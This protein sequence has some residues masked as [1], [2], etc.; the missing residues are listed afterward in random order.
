[1]RIVFALMHYTSEFTLIDK[2][3]GFGWHLGATWAQHVS[4]VFYDATLLNTIA[5]MTHFVGY[6]L[7]THSDRLYYRK[8]HYSFHLV[9]VLFGQLD[10]LF[11]NSEQLIKQII[12]LN[13]TLGF[14]GLLLVSDFCFVFVRPI[15]WFGDWSVLGIL[16]LAGNASKNRPKK[17]RNNKKTWKLLK[18]E[19]IQACD[20]DRI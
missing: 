6:W 3:G 2:C 11:N 8:H 17:M 13:V 4:V 1:M 20:E 9:T 15:S 18:A 16:S 10:I 14:C 5:S 12:W 7:K 19:K